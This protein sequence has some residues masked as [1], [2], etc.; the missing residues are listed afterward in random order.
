MKLLPILLLLGSVACGQQVNTDIFPAST[1]LNLGHS[2]QRW[3]TFFQNVDIT[4][5]CTVKGINCIPSVTTNLGAT[6]QFAFYT[7][8]NTIGPT[9]NLDDGLTTSGIITSKETIAAPQF[10]ALGT[11]GFLITSTGGSLPTVGTA[12][13][14]IGIST[15]AI[16]QI[17]PNNTGWF[18]I[19]YITVGGTALPATANQTNFSNSTPAP[20]SNGL[21]IQWQTSGQNISA[22]IVGDGN[23]AHALCGNG[24]FGVCT[25]GGATALSGLTAAVGANTIANGNNPQTWNWAQTT[26]SQIGLTFGETSA[27]TAGTLTGAIANQAEV[28]ATTASAS[29]ATPFNITQG[30]VTGTVAFPAFQIQTTWNNAGLTGEGIVF[31]VTDTSSAVASLALDL[32][33]G[34]TTQFSVDKNGNVLTG[35]G[36]AFGGNANANNITFC[37]SSAINGACSST[38]SGAAGGAQFQGGDASG[39]G[40]S[41][42]AGY[43]IFRGGLLTAASPNAAA[44]EGV[45]QLEAG[46]LK[47][48]AIAAMGDVVCGTTTAFTVT[49]C[50]HTGPAVNIIGIATNTSNPIGVIPYGTALVK[51]DGAVTIG[52]I[53]CMGTTT[54]GQAHDNGTAVCATAGTT[55]GIVVATS[56]TITQ[57]SGNTTSSTAMST[58]LPLV[59]LHIGK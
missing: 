42:K 54:D 56:G 15:G 6:S 44:L 31:N 5:T 2:N 34:G 45:A 26:N 41:V 55:I 14:G 58:T 33:K 50:S 39:T 8:S 19:P 57:A 36:G 23:A 29:T 13:G 7:S 40:S 11:G 30:S 10:T 4:G 28:S 12:L 38:A 37:G 20:P 27:A 25:A 18:A 46:Y 9:A 48:S 59:Q 17:N 1:G 52:D 49:D 53:L 22:A 21:N 43:G 32:R 51:T 47:G 16:P 3:N 24:T 35:S